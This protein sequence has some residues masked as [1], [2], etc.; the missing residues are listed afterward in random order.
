MSSKPTGFSSFVPAALASSLPVCLPT[1]PASL[2]S[3]MTAP[4]PSYVP[5]SLPSSHQGKSASARMS[6]DDSRSA[7]ALDLL[8]SLFNGNPVNDLMSSEAGLGENGPCGLESCTVGSS[9]CVGKGEWHDHMSW[10]GR[11]RDVVPEQNKS[12]FRMR[13]PTKPVLSLIHI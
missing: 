10:P 13:A 3:F 1:I 8:V 7:S 2:P 5:A 9:A 6:V 11:Q 12:R 4:L